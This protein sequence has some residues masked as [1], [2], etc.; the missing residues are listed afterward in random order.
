MATVAGTQVL[1]T[2]GE[3]VD[4]QVLHRAALAARPATDREILDGLGPA[5][6]RSVAERYRSW[7]KSHF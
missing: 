7:L 3:A 1:V 4:R 6:H 2:G 5:P